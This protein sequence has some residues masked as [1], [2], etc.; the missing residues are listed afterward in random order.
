MADSTPHCSTFLAPTAGKEL[1][2]LWLAQLLLQPG[3]VMDRLA[4]CEW[5]GQACAHTYSVWQP[6]GQ[7]NKYICFGN[8]VG[9]GSSCSLGWDPSAFPYQVA[10]GAAGYRPLLLFP[11]W[12]IMGV[13]LLPCPQKS[14]PPTRVKEPGSLKKKKIYWMV[15]KRL[16]GECL[17]GQWCHL[18]PALPES[19]AGPHAGPYLC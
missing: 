4:M 3:T 13:H 1:C 6:M 10:K 15:L 7:R 12:G 14:A 5:R 9:G 16:P 18:R 19:R 17:W 8:A 11:R 2:H